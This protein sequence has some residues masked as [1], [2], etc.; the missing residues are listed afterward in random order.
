ME[1][2]M[3]AAKSGLAKTVAAGQQHLQQ[4]LAKYEQSQSQSQQYSGGS[5]NSHSSGQHQYYGQQQYYG[6]QNQ[7]QSQHQQHHQQ[8]QLQQQQEQQQHQQPSRPATAQHSQYFAP[9]PPASP[10]QQG[11]HHHPPPH[12]YHLTGPNHGVG[13]YV[14]PVGQQQ[15]SYGNANTAADYPASGPSTPAVSPHGQGQYASY[16]APPPPPPPP[17]PT[18]YEQTGVVKK[19]LSSPVGGS[20]SYSPGSMYS[21]APVQDSRHDVPESSHATAN[22]AASASAAIP[23]NAYH[24][25]SQQLAS[26]ISPQASSQTSTASPLPLNAG[27]TPPPPP[28]PPPPLPPPLPPSRAESTTPQLQPQ[29]EQPQPRPQNESTGAAP[30]HPDP[31]HWTN[32]LR[33]AEESIASFL[34]SYRPHVISYTDSSTQASGGGNGNF[35]TPVVTSAPPSP[36]HPQQHGAANYTGMTGG[37]SHDA[38]QYQASAA[39]DDVAAITQAISHLA[40][41]KDQQQQQQQQQDPAAQAKPRQAETRQQQETRS[42][43]TATA[44]RQPLPPVVASGPPRDVVRYCPEERV[45]DYPLYWYQLPEEPE[46]LVCTK[47]HQDH[48]KS[49]PLEGHFKRILAAPEAQSTCRFWSPRVK[50]CLWKQALQSNDMGHLTSF[51]KRRLAIPNCKGL[52]TVRGDKDDPIKW[53]G[54]TNNEISSFIVCEACYEDKIMGTAF[55]SRL[56]PYKEQGPQDEWT[57]DAALPYVARALAE[58]SKSNDWA[59]FVSNTK[60]RMTYPTCEGKD[61][62]WNEGVWFTPRRKLDDFYVCGACYMDR[63]QLTE[64]EHE[65]EGVA[66]TV[67]FDSWM[68]MLGTRW[69]C[70]MTNS[71]LAMCFAHDAYL[72]NKDFDGFWTMASVLNTLVPCTAKGII[73]GKWWTIAGA[74]GPSSEAFSICEAC[75]HGIFKTNQLDQF[76]EPAVRNP[77]DTIVCSFCPAAPRFNQYIRKFAEALD[78]SVFSYYTDYIAQFAAVPPCPRLDHREKSTWWGYDQVLFCQDCYLSFV[79]DTTLGK[80]HLQYYDASDSRAQ[81]CQMWS[82]RMRQHWRQVCEAG[83]PGS[84]AC[85]DALDKFKAFGQR[86]LEV[87]LQTVPRI[88]FIRAMKEMKMMNAMHQGQLSLMYSGMNS[89]AVL[90]DTTDGY[91]HGNSSLGWYETEH[92]A[93]GAQMFNNMQAG[94]ANANRMDEWA[95]ILQLQMMWSEV[96]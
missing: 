31:Q 81:I 73:R 26:S 59:G 42:T 16:V 18:S 62:A 96:E 4:R 35:Q 67:G 72:T 80:H 2:F 5:S 51:M 28:P 88:R 3:K 95:E 77:Q 85:S 9:P 29:P 23:V 40:V 54:M 37:A 1:S 48:I 56:T 70:K 47:C 7:H 15:Q 32:R 65:F 50:D 34:P 90:S 87:Y 61:I 58:L 10:P 33:R 17:R 27:F 79:A 41:E 24:P 19:P 25:L 21:A 60:R 49:T 89:M 14:A 78:R 57:C 82:P 71:N 63:M 84:A 69:T 52:V 93:T 38:N 12:G 83:A 39:R 43:D 46:F 53:F 44:A 22:P 64:F 8:L 20:D 30:V 13:P 76:L 66:T 75:F 94:F 74:Q 91:A 36:P 68:N 45:V 92:G 6:N 55:Q 86:R 11:Q